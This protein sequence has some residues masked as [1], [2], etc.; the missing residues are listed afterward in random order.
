VNWNCPAF[1]GDLVRRLLSDSESASKRSIEKKTAFLS[2]AALITVSL[3]TASATAAEPDFAAPNAVPSSTASA[4]IARQKSIS[5]PMFFE[6]NQGQSDPR[7]RFLAHGEGYGLFLTADEALLTLRPTAGI[8]QP[9]P[10][11]KQ[12]AVIEMH[13]AGANAGAEISGAELLPGKSDYFIGNDRSKWRQGIPQFGRVE[14][15][16]VY[17]GVNLDYYGNQEQLEYDFHVAPGADPKQIALTFSGADVRIDSGRDASGTGDLVLSTPNGEMRFRAPHIYQ[18]SNGG[19]PGASREMTVAGGFQQLADGKIGFSIGAYDH[20]REL[21][22]DPVLGYST[23]FGPGPEGFVKIAVDA[24]GNVYLAESTSASGLPTNPSDPPAS[25]LSST[26]VGATNIFVAV[27]NI[28][29]PPTTQ[30]LYGA[31]LGGSDV[32]QLAGVAVDSQQNIYLAG[33]TTSGSSFPTVNGIPPAGTLVSGTPHGFLSRIGLNLTYSLTF[34]TVLAGNGSD[35]VTGLAIDTGCGSSKTCNAYVTGNTTSSNVASSTAPFPASTNGFQLVSNSPGNPQFFASQINVF[36]SGAPSMLYSTYF[37]GGYPVSAIAVG[38]GIAVDSSSN[39]YFSGTT[40][41]LNAVPSGAGYAPFPIIN[42]QQ[43]CLNESGQTSCGTQTATTVTDGFVAKINPTLSGSLSNPAYSTYVGGAGQDTISAI[44]VDTSGNAYITGTTT[45]TTPF[46]CQNSCLAAYQ[47]TFSG[48]QDAYIA[49]IQNI[50]GTPL[51]YFSYLGPGGPAGGSGVAGGNDIKVDSAFGVHVA[52]YVAGASGQPPAAPALLGVSSGDTPNPG[53]GY[54][55][56]VSLIYASGL[57]TG[58]YFGY[59]GGSGTEYGTGIALDSNNVPYVAGTTLSS[60]F[61]VSANAYLNTPTGSGANSFVTQILPLSSVSF[62]TPAPTPAPYPAQAGTADI[63]S[64]NITN[65][66]PDTASNVF[67]LAQ[68][69]AGLSATT[70]TAIISTGSGTCGTLNQI[71]NTISCTITTLPVCT[72]TCTS[73]AQV[74]VSATAPSTAN[75]SQLLVNAQLS[76]IGSS[77]VS[78]QSQK[79]PVV[80]FTVQASTPT[81]V[82]AGQLI[83]ININFCP[84]NSTYGYN[85]T[86][87]P[88]QSTT[89][90]MVTASSPVFSPTTVPLTGTACGSTTLNIQTV[91]RPVTNTGLF[92]H[93]SFYAAWLPIGGLSLVG[94]GFSATRRRRWLAGAALGMIAG[95]IVLQ[96]ACGSSSTSVTTQTGTAAGTYTITITGAAGSTGSD[97]HQIPVSVRV[98]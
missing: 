59:F 97:S 60:N 94:F 46:V 74:Q 51:Q 95:I 65:A 13:L 9:G 27:L 68:L 63:F 64:F 57:V 83:T 82:T 8:G 48:S 3:F 47:D 18:L 93:G 25:P 5:I 87:T 14:Y 7:V 72:G 34:S 43:S 56:F 58:N 62:T 80:D 78:T 67:F 24:G 71:N 70:T 69:Q 81:A 55:A 39:M 75:F 52:G 2:A 16:S 20:N 37:G 98:N 26:L 19:Q 45:T 28:S 6:P 32:D 23:Y 31:Y 17:P 15:R 38:G 10:V 41:M 79:S 21:V 84:N 50:T 40:N 85:G 12:T 44:T 49:E 54:D 4:M 86:I 66:G 36:G 77:Q 11:G 29:N 96:S 33:T 89:P 30:L 22:I 88:S 53:G 35:T 76:S 92:R 1:G 42:G 61:P 90:S 73:N 91:A